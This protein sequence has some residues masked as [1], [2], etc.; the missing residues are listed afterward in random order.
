[1]VEPKMNFFVLREN[2]K[3]IQ[4]WADF[5]EISQNFVLPKSSIFFAKLLQKQ[6]TLIFSKMSVIS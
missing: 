3:I 5:C 4:N 2:L 6:K 1:M